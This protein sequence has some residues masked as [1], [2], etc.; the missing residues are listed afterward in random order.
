[1]RINPLQLIE[2]GWTPSAVLHSNATVGL[3]SLERDEGRLVSGFLKVAR[4]K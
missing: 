2:A 4:Q 1:M 3:A